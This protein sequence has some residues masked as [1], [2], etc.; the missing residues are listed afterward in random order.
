MLEEAMYASAFETV[1]LSTIVSG[2]E[3]ERERDASE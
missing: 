3:R 1:S 2:R